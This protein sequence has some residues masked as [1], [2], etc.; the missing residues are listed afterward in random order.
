MTK[1]GLI[2]KIAKRSGVNDS[3]AKIFFEM[4]LI[5]AAEMLVPGEAVK[6]REFGYFQK[7]KG[8]VK[9]SRP[10]GEEDSVKQFYT[11][12]MVYFPTAGEEEGEKDVIFN[13]P[14]APAEENYDIDSYFSLSI[15]KPVISLKGVKNTEFFI[16]PSGNE[17][18]KL[19]ESKAE[20]LLAEAKVIDK[21][22][23][24]GEILQIT[25]ENFD[26]SQ[27][28]INW[29]ETPAETS[30]KPEMAREE[31]EKADELEPISWN[32]GEDISK[33]IE[34]EAIL[35]LEKE[36]M[37][38]LSWDF[39]A[40]DT[41]E[42]ESNRPEEEKEPEPEEIPEKVKSESEVDKKSETVRDEQFETSLSETG[43]FQ[44]VQ[45]LIK[46]LDG[47]NKPENPADLGEGASWDFR[48]TTAALP[49]GE[50]DSRGYKKVHSRTSAFNVVL[51]SGDHREVPEQIEESVEVENIKDYS[52]RTKT[53]RYSYSN[54][55]S[56]FVFVV[57]IST[58][59]IVGIVLYMYLTKSSIMKMNVGDGSGK[60]ASVLPVSH[61]EIIDRD[62]T[63]PINYPYPKNDAPNM[64]LN[65][66]GIAPAVFKRTGKPETVPPVEEPIKKQAEAPKT[67]AVK[68]T[69]PSKA[70]A[71]SSLEKINDRIFRSG[72]SYILQVSSW[73]SESYANGQAAK[74]KKNGMD[75]FVEKAVI[76]G[77]GT[78]YR[79][80]IG[81]FK[82]V[83]DVQKF[84]KS[85]K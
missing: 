73:K 31:E 16:P 36:E 40:V 13:V 19:M 67:P 32:F 1:A 69:S 82:S 83:D 60:A 70:I 3:E 27:L 23:K 10:A 77:R 28:E 80:R 4:F 65:G 20:K 33:Q 35:D 55:K 2:R 24:G 57:A 78:W 50:S 58:I 63:I 5:K 9:S 44:R 30:D 54:N 15:G 38:D 53:R 84:L 81:G 11:T 42:N 56:P 85:H 29:D 72:D 66:M 71:G 76:P 26:R 48:R 21:H 25:A 46:G 22:I 74:Y 7:R 45:T 51:P 17:L 6:L 43:R 59:V 61:P 47:E 14:S 64:D 62:F 18:L 52:S 39:G 75:A 37:P 79:V 68:K 34:E 8:V 49:D 12:L 41:F